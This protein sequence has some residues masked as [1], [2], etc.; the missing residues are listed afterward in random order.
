L[1]I[2]SNKIICQIFTEKFLESADNIINFLIIFNEMKI[3][4]SIPTKIG[5]FVSMRDFFIAG[6]Q[7]SGTIPVE[8]SKLTNLRNFIMFDNDF[9]G[10]IPK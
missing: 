4:G 10:G 2:E 8:M 6:N 1:D 5:N 9:T 7:L 3:S